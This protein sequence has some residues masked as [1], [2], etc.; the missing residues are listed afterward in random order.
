MAKDKVVH[1]RM[2]QEEKNLFYSLSAAAGF[3]NPAEYARQKLLLDADM[4]AVKSF[5]AD[6]LQLHEKVSSTVSILESERADMKAA[7]EEAKELIAK[8]IEKGLASIPL[9]ECKFKD[10]PAPKSAGQEVAFVFGAALGA[11]AIG[12]AWFI[13]KLFTA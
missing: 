1:V 4:Q 12:G 3:I 2:T 5:S 10:L 11:L 9:H 13:S 8:S 7:T 6:M